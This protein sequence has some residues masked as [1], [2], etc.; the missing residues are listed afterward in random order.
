MS[1]RPSDEGASGE[2]SQA[3]ATSLRARHSQIE[4]SHNQHARSVA[5][6]ETAIARSLH[7]SF[8]QTEPSVPYVDQHTSGEVNRKQNTNRRQLS[9]VGQTTPHDQHS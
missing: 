1:S 3:P 8:F 9:P 4:H 6:R 7:L 5:A 2:I